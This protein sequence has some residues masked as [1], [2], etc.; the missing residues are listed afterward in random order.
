MLIGQ[1]I[2]DFSLKN[3]ANVIKEENEKKKDLD[4]IKFDVKIS[5]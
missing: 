4:G 2:E 5:N 3:K 1:S